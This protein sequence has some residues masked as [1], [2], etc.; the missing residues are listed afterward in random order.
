[1]GHKTSDYLISKSPRAEDGTVQ[2]WT[3]SRG[4]TRD[5]MRQSLAFVLSQQPTLVTDSNSLSNT[6]L[7]A[8]RGR[9]Q[10]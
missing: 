6:L 7:Q 2:C 4:V 9:S 5:T 8:V 1:M 10:L 3:E